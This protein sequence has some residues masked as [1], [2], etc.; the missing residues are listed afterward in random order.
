M[1]QQRSCNSTAA[2]ADLQEKYIVQL[3][4]LDTIPGIPEDKQP[5][6]E[7]EKAPHRQRAEIFPRSRLEA[8]VA[9]LAVL[10]RV[11]LVVIF[12]FREASAP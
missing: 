1:A 7:V 10:D 9:P 12:L 2:R 3:P 5:N 4:E 6:G 8:R 11:P